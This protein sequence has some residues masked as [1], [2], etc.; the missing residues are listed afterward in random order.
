MQND[1][2]TRQTAGVL[3]NICSANYSQQH[4]DTI[5]KHH[6]GT[7]Q[8]FLEDEKFQTWLNTPNGT[9]FCPGVPGAGKTI[10]AALV[11]EQLLRSVKDP[12]HP[13]VFIYCNYK[14]QTEQSY[15]HMASTILRQI[16]QVLPRIPQAIYDLSQHT[17]TLEEITKALHEQLADVQGL[18][19]VIDAL[20]ECQ[21]STRSDLVS[22]IEEMQHKTQVRLMVTTRDFHAGTSIQLLQA[23]P[24]LEVKAS[25]GDLERYIRSR[26]KYLRVH[27]PADLQEDLVR[28]VVIAADGM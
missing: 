16:L 22:L 28:G 11:I 15:M 12:Q 13:I 25:P 7:G 26:L 23:Q 8:W 17:P 9:L 1:I 14:R 27:V 4:R 2:H 5:A 10:M 18:T 3:D 21:R 6:Q 19:I 20:D 24:V